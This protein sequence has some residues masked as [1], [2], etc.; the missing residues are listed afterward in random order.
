M[1]VVLS[2]PSDGDFMLTPSCGEST[3]RSS[4]ITAPAVVAVSSLP[5]ENRLKAGLSCRTACAGVWCGGERSSA[6][7]A[8]RNGVR[9]DAVFAGSCVC[10][11]DQ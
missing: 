11:I 3:V 10:D 4:C 9:Q 2:I 7:V 8:R 1:F 5:S 6:P